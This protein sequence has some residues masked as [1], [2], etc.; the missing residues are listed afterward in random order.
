MYKFNL[1]QSE[2]MPSEF[3]ARARKAWPN[4]SRKKTQVLNLRLLASSIIWTGMNAK[5]YQ[6]YYWKDVKRGL[7]GNP[8]LVY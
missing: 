6:K 5:T 2:H 1:D 8:E 4:Q 3:N 7:S